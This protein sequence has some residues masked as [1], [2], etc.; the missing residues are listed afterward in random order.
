MNIWDRVLNF[1]S[2]RGVVRIETFG[3]EFANVIHPYAFYGVFGEMC[4][5]LYD[6]RK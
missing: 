2:Q 4:P 6:L 3:G 1:D 5:E